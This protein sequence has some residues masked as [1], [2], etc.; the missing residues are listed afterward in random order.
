MAKES[1]TAGGPS[2][3]SMPYLLQLPFVQFR[4]PAG[5]YFTCKFLIK[6]NH[7]CSI[8]ITCQNYT[9]AMEKKSRETFGPDGLITKVGLTLWNEF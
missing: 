1:Q 4:D 8:G 3:M 6:A 7:N 2:S 5:G 9:H